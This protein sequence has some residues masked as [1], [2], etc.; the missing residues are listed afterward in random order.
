MHAR[1][2]WFAGTPSDPPGRHPAAANRVG[3][4]DSGG[5]TGPPGSDRR[6]P[7]CDLDSCQLTAKH[8]VATPVNWRPGQDVIFAV[9]NNVSAG[10]ITVTGTINGAITDE[11]HRR[12]YDQ[13]AANMRHTLP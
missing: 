12:Q 10:T 4:G 2:Y 3:N 5:T 8:T 13:L 1:G 7:A 9:P 6:L 11:A